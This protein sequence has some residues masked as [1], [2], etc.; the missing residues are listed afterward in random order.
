MAEL[1]VEFDKVDPLDAAVIAELNVRLPAHTDAT[2]I[3]EVQKMAD[4]FYE[5][6]TVQRKIDVSIMFD[7]TFP[8]VYPSGTP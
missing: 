1:L 5:Q 7:T 3:S 6:G 4:A 8:I 2:V